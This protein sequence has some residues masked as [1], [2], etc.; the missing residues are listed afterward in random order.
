MQG[1]KAC[2]KI[3]NLSWI[4]Y[5]PPLTYF[6]IMSLSEL[7]ARWDYRFRPFAGRMSP[8]LAT[9]G[10]SWGRMIFQ[11]VFFREL[12][13]NSFIS[14]DY[15]SSAWGLNFRLPLWN[16]AGM[17]K[18]AE[19]YRIAV[20]Q[21]AGA[22][23]C[24]TTTSKPRSGNKRR[25]IRCPVVSLPV[26]GA[27]LNWM[28]LPNAGHQE[29]ARRIAR[30]EKDPLCPVFASLAADP[31]CDEKVAHDGLVE[32]LIAYEKAG[33][34]G[35]E[36]NESCPNVAGHGNADSPLLDIGLLE[37]L[38][39]V[40]REF[41][42]K[43]RRRMPVLV[44]VSTDTHHDALAPLVQTLATMGF[45]G[46]VIGNTSTAYETIKSQLMPAD[47]RV[48]D[49]FT[50]AFG[51]GISGAPLGR[52]SLVKAAQASIVA[53]DVRA[54]DEFR[55][56]R[57]GGIASAADIMDSWSA[58]IS[59]NQWYTGYYAAFARDGHSLYKRLG[60]ELSALGYRRF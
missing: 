40:S 49:W 24:G 41:L 35:I 14:Q 33:V 10:A 47:Q 37:R 17:F 45:D 11:N 53:S 46:V 18:G 15:A 3:T 27:A 36:I 32:G 12:P 2:S 22:W 23:V 59:F 7:L 52:S 6:C 50:K 19:G 25:G 1:M 34:D 44:K 42:K 31:G 26:S 56:I 39:A 51:G 58:G 20:R 30:L 28:G 60:E 55:V 57:V 48:V 43:R 21:G 5:F 9:V 38:E 29:V 4:R 16:A 13:P 8:F 54:L